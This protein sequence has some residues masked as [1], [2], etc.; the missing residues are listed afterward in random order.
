[1]GE[2]FGRFC[3]DAKYKS[4]MIGEK[5]KKKKPCYVTRLNFMGV[6]HA[7]FNAS[8]V[9]PIANLSW[10]RPVAQSSDTKSLVGKRLFITVKCPM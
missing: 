3:V 7:F 5:P 9:F 2:I 1:M 4:I 10:K 6:S 8:S